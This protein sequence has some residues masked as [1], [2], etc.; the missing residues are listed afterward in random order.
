MVFHEHY[1]SCSV[2]FCNLSITFLVV[3]LFVVCYLNITFLVVFLF[4]VWYLNIT[5]LVVFQE[6]Y[7]SCSVVFYTI[8]YYVNITFLVMFVL[9]VLP[10]CN[11]YDCIMCIRMNIYC[12]WYSFSW[13]FFFIKQIFEENCVLKDKFFLFCFWTPKN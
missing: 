8:V 10:L 6:H 12:V 1:L 13:A 5:L 11:D 3:F 2:V 9:I 7:L 4:V